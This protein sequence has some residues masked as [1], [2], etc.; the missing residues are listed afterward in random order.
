MGFEWWTAPAVLLVAIAAERLHARRVRAVAPLLLGRSHRFTPL[1]AI[2]PAVRGLALAAVA[3]GTTVLLVTPPQQWEGNVTASNA[4][5]PKD[6]KRLLILLDVSP[7]MNLPD[8]DAGSQTRA[9]RA[10]AVLDNLSARLDLGQT[11]VSIV[12]FY[13]EARPVVVDAVDPALVH[14][15]ATEATLEHAFEDGLTDLHAGVNAALDLARDWRSNSAT[16]VVI[17]DGDSVSKTPVN[18]RPPSIDRVLVVGVGDAVSGTFINDHISRHDPDNLRQLALRLRGRYVN[19]DRLFVPSEDIESVS[20]MLARTVAPPRDRRDVALFVLTGG[21]VT[22]AA[23]PF[24]LSAF[25]TVSVVSRRRRRDAERVVPAGE[26][27]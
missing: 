13:T 1:A 24:L 19:A 22:L 6:F 20:G 3:W 9:A 7:S 10:A 26:A 18:D 15:F 25:G 2:A 17:T 27:R 11:R 4:V 8:A 14:F 16:L 5:T 12:P 23:L 21:S